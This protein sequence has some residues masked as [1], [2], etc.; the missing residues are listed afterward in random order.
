[1]VY[2]RRSVS[3][4]CKINIILSPFFCRH[5]FAKKFDHI[6]ANEMAS[7]TANMLASHDGATVRPWPKRFT[8]F[9]RNRTALTTVIESP[10]EEKN[11]NKER[12]GG[13]L[14]KL[15][16]EMIRRMDDAPKLIDPSGWI[17][18][19]QSP[20]LTRVPTVRSSRQIVFVENMPLSSSPTPLCEDP[21]NSI[22]GA[23]QPVHSGLM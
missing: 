14:Q 10:D 11:G 18:E 9:F 5:Y 6:I 7:R 1:M 4:R 12:R 19:G 3:S 13:A 15:R 23:S 17:S 21:E 2:I 16:P 22:N 8:T 20:P